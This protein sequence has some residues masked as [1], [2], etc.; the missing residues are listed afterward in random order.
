MPHDP[1][2]FT[3]FLVFTGAALLA[4]LALY[5]RQSLLVAYMVLGVLAGPSALGLAPGEEP[6]VFSGLIADDP[7]AALRGVLRRELLP[8]GC[9]FSPRCHARLQRCHSE[10]PP[11][12]QVAENHLAACHLLQ[13]VEAQF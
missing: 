2:F 1:I 4:T 12:I 5:A 7:D 8:P 13:G 3:I 11:L 6:T 9:R 10:A